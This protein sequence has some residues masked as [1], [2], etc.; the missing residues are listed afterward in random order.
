M[1][2]TVAL[3]LGFLLSCQTHAQSNR[4]EQ[5]QSEI[6]N[7]VA[8]MKKETKVNNMKHINQVEGFK[9]GL[10]IES[11]NGGLW[12]VNY[13]MG[14][15]DGKMSIYYTNGQKHVDATYKDG[16]LV[17]TVKFYDP[18]GGLYYTYENIEYNDSIVERKK[19]KV[20]GGSIY[21]AKEKH[22]FEYRAYA[23]KY[24]SEGFLYKEGELLF[25]DEWIYSNFNIGEWKY[26][27]EIH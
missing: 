2:V 26:H 27:D 8:E 11:T 17:D 14:L 9:D 16:F 22:R 5:L 1:K 25:D 4:I 12:F 18:K 23:K 19:A 3:I 24:T 20:E 10:W 6:A 13:K 7:L 21:F 15:K